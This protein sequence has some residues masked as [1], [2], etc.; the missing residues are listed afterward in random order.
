MI[1]CILLASGFG[2]RFGSN[3][4]IHEINGKPMFLHTL[5]MLCE[6]ARKNQNIKVTIVTQYEE[7]EEIAL[8]M[9]CKV[10]MNDHA[11]EGI[12]ASV[13][14][15]VE[16]SQA[17][18]YF[19]FTAD[20]PYLTGKT[21]ESFLNNGIQSGRSLGSVMASGRPGNPTFFHKKWRPELLSLSGDTGGRKILKTHSEEIFWQEINENEIFDIDF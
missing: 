13:R 12:A 8:T 1:E 17:D 11:E 3:K 9:N 19:F 4:L 18:W 20:Q 6:L 21:V 16:N 2:R 7:I 5:E 14:L 10:L 15:G